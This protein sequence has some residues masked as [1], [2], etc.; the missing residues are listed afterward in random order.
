MIQLGNQLRMLGRNIVRLEGI[1]GK[2]IEL[3]G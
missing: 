2:V 1:L 3:E